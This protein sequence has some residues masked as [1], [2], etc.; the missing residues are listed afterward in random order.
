MKTTCYLQVE[1]TFS[2]WDAERLR[3]ITVK[4]V[5]QKYPRDPLPGVVVLK[6]NLDIADAAFLP[7]KPAVDVSIPVEHTEAITVASDPIEIPTGG[8]E[9]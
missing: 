7:L 6:I 4:R 2:N 3:S 9:S 1:P 8:A 5:T